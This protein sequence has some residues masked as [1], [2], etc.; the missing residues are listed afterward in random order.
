MMQ[1]AAHS[2]V[3]G[4]WKERIALLAMLSAGV[5]CAH[6]HT[7]PPPSAVPATKPDLER[8]VETGIPVASTPQGLMREGAEK[9]IQI[10]LKEKRLLQPEQVTGQFD[11][12]TRAALK[13]FQ[14]SKGLPPTGLPSYETVDKL[15]LDL[16][17]VFHTIKHPRQPAARPANSDGPKG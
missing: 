15:G 5:A 9:K 8:A 4:H 7:A 14:K 16:D 10:R 11:A 2:S 1:T 6:P 12:D 17:T 3:S 13:K